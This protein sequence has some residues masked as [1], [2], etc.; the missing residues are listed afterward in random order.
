MRADRWACWMRDELRL[1]GDGSLARRLRC[2]SVASSRRCGHPSFRCALWPL[3]LQSSSPT[4][5]WRSPRGEGRNRLAEDFVGQGDHL[6]NF[7]T[8]LLSKL[9]QD[10]MEVPPPARRSNG[11]QTSSGTPPDFGRQPSSF[12]I[13]PA[14]RC[15]AKQPDGAERDDDGDEVRPAYRERCDHDFKLALAEVSG[16]DSVIKRMHSR[17]FHVAL[18]PHS[19]LN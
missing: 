7:R 9:K 11:S 12:R 17:N 15:A 14:G 13:Q 3:R 4:F 19:Q 10:P 6:H 8:C 2:H 16:R 1:V 5:F 18:T